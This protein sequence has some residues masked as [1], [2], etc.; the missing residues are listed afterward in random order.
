MSDA[1][2][3]S[4]WDGRE[5][6]LANAHVE[7]RWRVEGGRLFASSFKD[8]VSGREWF[9][10]RSPL[11]SP[12]PATQLPS[13]DCQWTC[14]TETGRSL[15]V[16]EPALR[17]A[18]TARWPQAAVTYRFE[19]FGQ[20]RGIAMQVES[21]AGGVGQ[22]GGAGASEAVTGVEL[23]DQKKARDEF[24]AADLLEFIQPA[25][26]H[27]RLIQVNL[28]DQTDIRNEL[29]FENE[30]LLHSNE[31]ELALQGCLFILEETLSG[32]GLVF[33]KEAPLPHVRPVKSGCDLRIRSGAMC[34]HAPANEYKPGHV[35]YPMAYQ[36]GLYGQGTG[37]EGGEGYRFVTLAYSG[38]RMGRISALQAYQRCRRAYVP[39]RDGLFLSNTWGD[40]NRDGRICESFMQQEVEAGAKLGVD[41]IQIDDGWQRGTTSN[42]VRPGGVWEGFHAADPRY[43]EADPERFPNGIEPVIAQA[44]A[45]G[46]RFG[47]WFSPDAAD[48]YANWERDAVRILELHRTLGVE[49]FKIDGVKARTKLGEWRLRDFFAKVLRE[50]DGNVIFDL[51]VTAEVRPGYFGRPEVGPLFV[52]NRYTDYHRYWPHQTLRNLWK[53]AHYVDP[54]RLRMEFLNNARNVELYAGDPLAPHA[55]SPAYLFASTMVG[56]PLGWFELSGL[57]AGYLAEL[58]MLIRVWREHRTRL[59]GGRIW[60]VGECPDGTS[61]TGFVS[62]GSDGGGYALLFREW[63]DRCCVRFELDGFSDN[64]R[65]A[66]VLSGKGV[67]R[68]EGGGLSVEMPGKL[69]YL[70]V[71]LQA[72]GESK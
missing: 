61:W 24:P 54:V 55:Y 6:I 66:T 7:R 33:L 69:S 72:N 38:G 56:S 59:H 20:T 46:L 18:L 67:A 34:F 62:V 27:L 4:S 42:S 29:V 12:V 64:L 32:D 44:R 28:F 63:T 26:T 39:G 13:G 68:L 48:D 57:P 65:Q 8:L 47:L 22:G 36:L 30:W 43:W 71:E 21:S 25:A 23:A 31:R 37:P 58:P 53:L 51:D 17:V 60:P 70:F 10:R 45:R 41:V 35:Q 3:R 9:V 16:E 49:C 19:V 14:S 40:R 5:L 15:P 2:W 1:P 11:A 52:E 50:S